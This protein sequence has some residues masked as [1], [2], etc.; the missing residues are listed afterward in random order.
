[1][2]LTFQ[3]LFILILAFILELFLPWWSI[4]L[5]A[6]IGGLLLKSK[7][8]FLAGFIAIALLWFFKAFIIDT[9]AA[10]TLTEKV[11]QIFKLPNKAILYMIMMLLGGLVGGFGCMAGGAVRK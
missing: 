5:V 9:M 8:N 3:I 11:A 1:M 2:R 4:A 6:F 7:Y 10:T